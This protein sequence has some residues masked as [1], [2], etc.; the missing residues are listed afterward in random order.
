MFFKDDV[1]GAKV[2]LSEKHDPVWKDVRDCIYPRE[3]MFGEMKERGR[4]NKNRLNPKKW[5]NTITMVIWGAKEHQ[6]YNP[7]FYKNRKE[8]LESL[9]DTKTERLLSPER[10]GNDILMQEQDGRL[11]LID[12]VNYAAGWSDDDDDYQEEELKDNGD[13]ETSDDDV[14]MTMNDNDD[15]GPFQIK[16][17]REI[18]PFDVKDS[19]EDSEDE[20]Q[21]HER[22]R[23]LKNERA[24]EIAAENANRSRFGRMEKRPKAIKRYVC[25]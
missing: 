18:E 20:E 11:G 9:R 2:Q 16:R 10:T 4:H 19:D 21:K 24:K 15:N 5:C 22:L 8:I 14:D 23:R 6:K 25:L 13:D 3:K 17:R 7:Q 1:T 12:G